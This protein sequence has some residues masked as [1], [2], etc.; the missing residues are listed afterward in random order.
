MEVKKCTH[1]GIKQPLSEFFKNCWYCK[2]CRK[3]MDHNNYISK[4]EIILE[5]EW[6]GQIR[7]R[8]KMTRADYDKLLIQQDGVCAICRKPEQPNRRL[9]IDHDH[10]CCPT[11][12]T[13]GKCIRGLLC[14]RCNR[15]SGLMNDNPL[16]LL[17][18]VIYRS[19]GVVT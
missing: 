10:F 2:T 3:E 4:R 14:L 1:C 5:K 8:Y 7:R 18:S 6:A 17:N 13:C 16:T 15:A 9:C 11:E 19:I 12:E